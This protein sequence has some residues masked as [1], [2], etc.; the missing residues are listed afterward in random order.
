[1]TPTVLLIMNLPLLRIFV[2]ILY[3]PT[4]ILLPLILG[5][6]S[7]GIY[8]LNNNVHDFYLVLLFGILGYFFRKVEIPTAPLVLALVIGKMMEQS[9][10]Q[11]MTISDAN[12]AIF[13]QSYISKILLIL[14]VLSVVIPLLMERRKKL[15]QKRSDLTS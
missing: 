2:R 6:S 4:G 5:I 14:T 13:A 9:F 11:A 7:V 12:P 10:R 8:T 15:K 3:V 1:M